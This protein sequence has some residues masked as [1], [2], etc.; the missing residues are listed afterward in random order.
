MKTAQK[1]HL[2]AL[3]AACVSADRRN[4]AAARNRAKAEAVVTYAYVTANKFDRMVSAAA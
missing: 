1:N 2:T 3:V 4:D